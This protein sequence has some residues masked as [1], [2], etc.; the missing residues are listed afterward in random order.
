MRRCPSLAAFA[1]LFLPLAASAGDTRRLVDLP[2]P[3]AKYA[4]RFIGECALNGLGPAVANE[5][6]GD[7]V[8]GK[9]DVNGDGRRDYLAYACMFGCEGAPFAFVTAGLPCASGVL[10]LSDGDEHK[11]YNIPGTVNKI[12][13]GE[14][15]RIVTTR[16]RFIHDP[17]CPGPNPCEYVFE[18]RDGRFQ[19]VGV[20]PPLGC[21][22]MLKQ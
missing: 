4:E 2:A 8:F 5:M 3:V 6:L 14:M 7:T 20:C 19:M 17:F 13:E 1:F 18:L 11:T 12:V 10:I 22:E 21:G 15:L 16:R 9:S